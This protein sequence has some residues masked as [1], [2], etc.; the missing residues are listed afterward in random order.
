MPCWTISNG[1][2]GGQTVRSVD[3]HHTVGGHRARG[4][5]EG[6]AG[7]NLDRAVRKVHSHQTVGGCHARGRDALDTCGGDVRPKGHTTVLIRNG[8][9]GDGFARNVHAHYTVGG[10]RARGQ[11]ALNTCSGAAMDTMETEPYKI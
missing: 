9:N 4:Q 2:D 3:A 11:G 5:G 1:H 6:N 7:D 8:H 10:R